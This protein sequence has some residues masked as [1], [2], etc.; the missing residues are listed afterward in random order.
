MRMEVTLKAHDLWTVIKQDKQNHKKD[1]LALSM[2]LISISNFKATKSKL[3]RVQR[4]IGRFFA[5]F[6]GVVRVV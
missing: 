2:I 4:R 1:H 3:R 5:H 6:V